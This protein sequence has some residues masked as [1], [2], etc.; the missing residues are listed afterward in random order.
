L[1]TKQL[2]FDFADK[3][4]V[5]ELA[6]D[7]TVRRVQGVLSTVLFAEARG[8][9]QVYVPEENVAEALLIPGIEVYGCSNLGVLVAHLEGTKPL[10]PSVPSTR[11]E[12]LEGEVCDIDLDHIVGQEQAKRALEI[13]AAGGHNII[14]VGPPGSGKTLLAR[15]LSGILPP[16][17]LEESLEVTKIYSVSGK[18]DKCSG[19]VT[20]RP[21]RAPHHTASTASLIGGGSFPKPGELSLAHRG[22]L[23]LD[24][25]TEFPKSIIESLRQPLEEG[26]VTVTRVKGSC[27]FPARSLLVAAMNP[28]PCGFFGDTDHLCSCSPYQ[29]L[30]YNQKISGPILDRIDLQVTVPRVALIK[31]ESVAHHGE[32]SSTVRARVMTARARQSARLVDQG[33]ITNSEMSGTE[34]KEA[35]HLGEAEKLFLREAAESLR[36]SARGYIRVLKVSRTIADLAGEETVTVAHLAEALQYRFSDE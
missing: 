20:K 18:L 10:T 7:G 19:L 27:H 29:I 31:L 6:L 21:M 9:K 25:F 17:S 16:L 34:T 28:C 5:G 35:T 22:V 24:E 23:F 13:A 1:A 15:A 12:Q 4:F 8:M 26:S 3:L 32:R 11:E 14:F 36:L 2:D 33:K 30:R